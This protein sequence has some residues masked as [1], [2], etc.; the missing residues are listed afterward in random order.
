MLKPELYV[1]WQQSKCHLRAGGRR[2]HTW[3]RAVK[4]PLTFGLVMAWRKT[5]NW[6][7]W[8]AIVDITMLKT[9]VA[10]SRQHQDHVMSM[11]LLVIS[12]EN[13]VY[14]SLCSSLEWLPGRGSLD[15][16]THPHRRWRNAPLQLLDS[17]CQTRMCH[18]R[19]DWIRSP[20]KIKTNYWIPQQNI[21]YVRNSKGNYF[22]QEGKHIALH[23]CSLTMWL[24]NDSE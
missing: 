9:W 16:Q 23:R 1:L 14:R 2:S 20:L 11:L 12:S 22:C 3:L 17:R 5:N 19:L 7:V 24:R 21:L 18:S 15:H 13:D 4:K 6:D 10:E 8:R